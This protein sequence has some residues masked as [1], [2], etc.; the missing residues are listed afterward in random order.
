MAVVSVI[1]P[2]YN[3]E[4]FLEHCLSS[5]QQQSFSDFEAL[6]I[7]DG[8][9]DTS[10]MIADSFAKNDDRF[11]VYHRSN[12]GVSASRNYGIENSI[13]SFISLIDADDSV[14]ADFLERLVT[15]LLEKG[16]DFSYCDILLE[17]PG[18]N[19]EHISWTSSADKEEAFHAFFNDGWSG[20]SVNKL[21]RKSFLNNYSLR[22]SEDIRYCEDL[23]FSIQV[24]TYAEAFE[25]VP[26]CLYHYNRLNDISATHVFN[27]ELEKNAFIALERIKDLFISEGKWDKYHRYIEWRMLLNK[28]GIVFDKNRLKE[29]NII[30]PEVN[31]YIWSNPFLHTKLRILMTLLHIRLYSLAKRI[32]LLKDNANTSL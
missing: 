1:V 14:S 30:H 27:R 17:E 28:I 26:G 20:A 2:V 9:T 5:I 12:H 21:Y 10:G 23:L 15:P 22:Y 29:F 13:G 11:R 4:R 6:I 19:S 16:L 8:S 32:L 31:K 7:D 24:L 18:G 25:K 3:G